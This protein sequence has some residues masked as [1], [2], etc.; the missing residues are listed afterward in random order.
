MFQVK[1]APEGY[2]V[3]V[4][5]NNRW[6]PLRNFGDRQG[7]ALE[8]CHWDCPKLSDMSIKALIKRYD[9]NVKYIRVNEKVFR[10]Q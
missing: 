4:Y 6:F 7:D 2:I 1:N 8:F 3:E 9:N 10:K 5:E